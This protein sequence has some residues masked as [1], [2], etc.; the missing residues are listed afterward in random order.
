MSHLAT[1]IQGEVHKLQVSRSFTGLQP[2]VR[3][4]CGPVVFFFFGVFTHGGFQGPFCNSRSLWQEGQI[5]MNL[6]SL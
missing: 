6:G 5:A 3:Q 4:A 2:T 1:L